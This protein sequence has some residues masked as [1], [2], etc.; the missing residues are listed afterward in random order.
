MTDPIETARREGIALGL[1][2]A[3]KIA[4]EMK[5]ISDAADGKTSTGPHSYGAGYD[6]GERA[7]IHQ[8]TVEIDAL[9]TIPP[10]VAAARV[11]L[12]ADLPDGVFRAIAGRRWSQNSSSKEV[13]RA[14]LES[15]A[16]DGE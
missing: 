1:A 7:V 2:M 16:K 9:T 4:V 11:L 5:A 6:A 13:F 14:A 10:H 3:R 8:F 15:I 12:D